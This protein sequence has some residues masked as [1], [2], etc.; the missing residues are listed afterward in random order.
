M[1]KCEKLSFADPLG[2][3]ASLNY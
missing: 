2:L 1:E 3:R